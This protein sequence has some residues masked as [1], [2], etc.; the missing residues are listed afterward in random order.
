METRLFV[1]DNI[2]INCGLVQGNAFVS[3]IDRQDQ[4]VTADR[5]EIFNAQAL[6][7]SIRDMILE[8]NKPGANIIVTRWGCQIIRA[9]R[10]GPCGQCSR[11]KIILL[12]EVDIILVKVDLFLRAQVKH[13]ARWDV[14]MVNAFY[15]GED[16][17]IMA[18]YADLQFDPEAVTCGPV[19]AVVTVE[20]KRGQLF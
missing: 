2:L 4:V 11:F 18:H 5:F 6:K 7:Q 19:P 10:K 17:Y 3:H 16:A 14:V 9:D 12:Q 20:I 1:L 15:V 8:D 13:Q